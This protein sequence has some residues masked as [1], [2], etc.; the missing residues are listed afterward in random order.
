MFT[1]KVFLLA[2]A[3]LLIGGPVFAQNHTPPWMLGPQLPTPPD[4]NP[5]APAPPK[6]VYRYR[7]QTPPPLQPGYENGVYKSQGVQSII[8]K[9]A[10]RRKMQ[11]EQAIAGAQRYE[12]AQ[13]IELER[14][15]KAVSFDS[16]MKSFNASTQYWTNQDLRWIDHLRRWNQ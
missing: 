3:S 1:K 4:Q 8:A 11:N 12:A 10:A 13:A 6:P 14:Y 16:Y 5:A 9:D 7:V 15:Q 2:A